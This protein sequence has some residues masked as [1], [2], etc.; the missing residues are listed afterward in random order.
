MQEVLNYI[1]DCGVYYIA[2][3]EGNQPRVRP[4]GALAEINGKLY[5]CTNNTKPCF[6]QMKA[7]PRVE[8][9]AMAADHT[10]VRL[11][12]TVT[13]DPSREIKV[14]MLEG[15]PSLQRMYT[16]DDGIFEVLELSDCTATFS[17]MG[18]GEPKVVT[19]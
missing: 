5:I 18:G 8:L 11:A 13:P 9:C 17:S 6:A 3:V 10:W 12:A 15:S 2:T 1:R 16:P 7:N 14:A 19:F 4:F